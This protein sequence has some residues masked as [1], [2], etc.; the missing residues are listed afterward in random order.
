LRDSREFLSESLEIPAEP[1]N[2]L[3][4]ND[5]CDFE[6]Y[7]AMGPLAPLLR[8]KRA[9][10]RERERQ[11]GADHVG[12]KGAVRGPSRDLCNQPKLFDEAQKRNPFGPTGGT[13]APVEDCQ[14][15]IRSLL[16]SIKVTGV[17]GDD[18]ASP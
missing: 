8:T 14:K 6:C 18:D 2:P 9:G 7:A 12:E 16:N 15:H 13:S 11:S 17:W 4:G 5:T 3:E 1:C 10:E